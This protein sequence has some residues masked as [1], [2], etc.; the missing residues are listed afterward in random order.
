MKSKINILVLN[1]GSSSLKYKLMEMPGKKEIISG[2]AERVGIKTADDSVITHTVLGKTRV[3]RAKLGN[4]KDAFIRIISLFEEDEAVNGDITIDQFAHRYVH[5]GFYFNKTTLI[6]DEVYDRLKETMDL[7]PIHN[8]ISFS[9]IEYC[10]ERFKNTP[11]YAVFDTTFH[12]TIPE[13][14]NTYALPRTMITKYNLHR[15]GFHGIS[16]KFVMEEACRFLDVPVKS[17]KI[18]SLHLGTGGASVCAIKNGKSVN[19]SMGFT[20]LE[21]L[22]MNTRSGDIDMGMFFH[23]MFN[24]NFSVDEAEKVLNNKSGVL[25]M[26]KVSSDLRDVINSLDHSPRAKLTYNMFIKRIRKYLGYNIV[27]LKKADI[28]IFTDSLGY[29]SPMIR[30]SICRG[31][32]FAG[33]ELDPVKNDGYKS[34]NEIISSFGSPTKVVV[35]P[36]NEELMIAKESYKEAE[37]V[38]NSRTKHK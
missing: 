1:C 34:G 26:F 36:T 25:G 17:Q 11:Q 12:N 16:H 38:L 3:T 15:I 6:D 22:I 29:C 4:H 27:L 35:I 10:H 30:E 21:G 31:F 7:A 13:E 19:S 37:N 28:V 2:E 33:I 24:E 9:L 23:L 14:L 18:I 5:P 32:E 8:P 20:P